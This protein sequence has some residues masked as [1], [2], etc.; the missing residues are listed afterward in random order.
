M[1]QSAAFSAI[2]ICSLQDIIRMKLQ[3]QI[4]SGLVVGKMRI[5]KPESPGTWSDNYGS[6]KVGVI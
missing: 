1:N 2:T 6:E 4:Y 5:V 3:M